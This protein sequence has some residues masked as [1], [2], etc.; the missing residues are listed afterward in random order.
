MESRQIVW[1]VPECSEEELARM[2]LLDAD[3]YMKKGKGKRVQIMQ[4]D[5]WT[6]STGVIMRGL[7]DYADCRCRPMSK[8]PS[9][10]PATVNQLRETTSSDAIV[11][12]IY[13][14]WT[15]R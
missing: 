7:S 4:P 15:N 10:P 12:L 5:A 9:A 2:D 13:T 1:F 6:M 11:D 3:G 14:S 8:L